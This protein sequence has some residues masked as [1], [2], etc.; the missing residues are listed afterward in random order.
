MGLLGIFG[1]G[2]VLMLLAVGVILNAIT[3]QNPII[4]MAFFIVGVVVG[5]Y[6]KE[7]R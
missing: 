3:K 4:I 5:Y 6:A 2:G 7:E 1:K